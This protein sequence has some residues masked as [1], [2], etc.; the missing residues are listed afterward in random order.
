[1]SNI[2]IIMKK[3]WLKLKLVPSII[4]DKFNIVINYFDEFPEKTNKCS[5]LSNTD[6]N[7]RRLKKGIKDKNINTIALLGNFSSGKSSI[8]SSALPDKNTLYVYPE[9]KFYEYEDNHEPNT[10][11]LQSLIKNDVST[12]SPDKDTYKRYIRTKKLIKLY[13]ISFIIC[14]LLSFIICLLFIFFGDTIK[15]FLADKFDVNTKNYF[16]ILIPSLFCIV[17]WII[18]TFYICNCSVTIQ[19]KGV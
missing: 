18:G 9:E 15:S 14:L 11:F 4:K 2:C 6:I 1:M 13:I 17:T 16:F 19:F 3:F 12:I 8:V 10:I 7:V 5:N